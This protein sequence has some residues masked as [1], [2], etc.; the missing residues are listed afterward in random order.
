MMHCAKILVVVSVGQ[1]VGR[2]DNV[3]QW[4]YN[5]CDPS[6]AVGGRCLLYVFVNLRIKILMPKY[7][8]V[9]N[10]EYCQLFTKL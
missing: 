10:W 7:P 2:V 1:G 3:L 9:Q 8:P 5:V 6:G 4:C